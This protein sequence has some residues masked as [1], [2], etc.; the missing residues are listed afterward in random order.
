MSVCKS[1]HNKIHIELGGR[2][3]NEHYGVDGGKI[4]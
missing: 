3:P 4:S 1:C 2:H